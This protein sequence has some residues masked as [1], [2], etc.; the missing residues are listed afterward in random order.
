LTQVHPH[1]EPAAECAEAAGAQQKFWELHHL[2]FENQDALDEASLIEYA[3]A[4]GVDPKLV[5]MAL[6]EHVYERNVREDF[7]SGV[8]SGVNGTPT[9]FIENVRYDGP[10]DLTSLRAIIEEVAAEKTACSRRSI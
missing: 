1:A 8:R 5:T 6:T 2:L 4:A 9:L 10:P 3:L 7:A